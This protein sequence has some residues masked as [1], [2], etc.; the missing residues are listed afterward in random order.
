MTGTR[1]LVKNAW[2][3]KETIVL[4]ADAQPKASIIAEDNNKQTCVLNKA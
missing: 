3:V 2:I 1:A 4:H